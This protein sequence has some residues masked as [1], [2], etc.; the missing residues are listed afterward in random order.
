MRSINYFEPRAPESSNWNPI[1]ELW[2]DDAS[3]MLFFLSANQIYFIEPVDDE[4]FSA[5]QQ[6]GSLSRTDYNGSVK[7]YLT[8]YPA[9]P[10]ACTE[11]WQFCNPSKNKCTPL[12]TFDDTANSALTNLYH[13][14]HQNDTFS[15][16]L[17]QLSGNTP[18]VS[19]VV[20]QLG[21]GS[22][23]ARSTLMSGQ[24]GQ[25][26]A[27][28]WQ[29]E[30]SGWMDTSLA[31]MQRLAVEAA[32]GPSDAIARE[33]NQKPSNMY[34]CKNQVRNPASYKPQTSLNVL[35]YRNICAMEL[36]ISCG[37]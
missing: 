27:D 10:L 11:Q 33:F 5:H 3:L 30:V 2:R 7:T 31:M 34:V 32:T 13:P 20:A 28:Q 18:S 1:P 25:L 35:L 17:M 8:D 24:Q 22:L 15:F 14:G 6:T 29:Q 26:P 16:W 21:I 9:N 4:W 12:G 23:K 19:N 37:R 36:P